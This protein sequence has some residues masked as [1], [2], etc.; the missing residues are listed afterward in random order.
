MQANLKSGKLSDERLRSWERLPP[1]TVLSDISGLDKS[2]VGKGLSQK[3][4][5][6]APKG[7]GIQNIG[8]VKKETIMEMVERNTFIFN[9]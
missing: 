1:F 5:R 9:L 3:K 6:K 7:A 8:Y 4:S 2:L